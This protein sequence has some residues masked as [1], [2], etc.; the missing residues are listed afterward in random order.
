MESHRVD[1]AA[2]TGFS[3]Q[4]G[5]II[6]LPVN[7]WA[8]QEHLY[9]RAGF[10][11]GNFLNYTS[12]SLSRVKDLNLIP[13]NAA[14]K[15]S[16]IVLCSLDNSGVQAIQMLRIGLHLNHYMEMHSQAPVIKTLFHH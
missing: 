3:Q 6:I 7:L 4:F 12:D 2:F 9:N 10:C 1:L 5:L 14:L 16:R 13:E 8:A 11:S 15:A